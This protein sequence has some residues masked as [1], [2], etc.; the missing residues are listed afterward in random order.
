MTKIGSNSGQN[1]PWIICEVYVSLDS[2]IHV[3][4]CQKLNM[5]IFISWREA[6]NFIRSLVTG[7]TERSGA[8]QIL[9]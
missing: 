7:G 6:R 3:F 4:S 2:Q 1:K 5:E 9:N 8:A